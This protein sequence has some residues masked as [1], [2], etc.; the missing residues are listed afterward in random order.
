MGGGKM[1]KI[2]FLGILLML[3]VALTMATVALGIALVCGII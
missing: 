3:I 2:D 1:R